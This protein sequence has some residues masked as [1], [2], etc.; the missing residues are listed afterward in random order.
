[1]RVNIKKRIKVGSKWTFAAIAKKDGKRLWD[2]CI[3][4]GKVELHKEGGYYIEWREIVDGKLKRIARPV[5]GGHKEAEAMARSQAQ[6]LDL[7]GHGHAVDDCVLQRRIKK[8]SQPLPSLNSADMKIAVEK[9]LGDKGINS[10]TGT[11]LAYS[12]SLKHFMEFMPIGPAKNL[13]RQDIKN[14]MAYLKDRGMANSTIRFHAIV[15][16]GMLRFAGAEITLPENQLPP[17]EESG[18]KPYEQE[19]IRKFLAACTDDERVIFEVFMQTGFR[20][21]E[22]AFLTWDDVDFKER[23]IRVSPKRHLDFSSKNYE[24]REITVPESL[25][26]NLADW[27][28]RSKGLFNPEQLVFPSGQYNGREGGKA[29]SE[30]LKLC[31]AIAYRGNLNCGRCK[32]TVRKT[33]LVHGKP[34]VRTVTYECK[35]GPHCKQWFLHRFRHTF[36]TVHLQFQTT[37]VRTVQVWLGHKDLATTIRYLKPA[38]GERIRKA[39]NDGTLAT[40]YSLSHEKRE[41]NVVNI[42]KGGRL[43]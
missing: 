33:V 10:K 12:S 22:V 30:F 20:N 36:A 35:N 38:R 34:E 2:H 9:Y 5:D 24:G 1:M 19:M 11:I 27:K 42:A 29:R 17:M 18:R 4:N 23:V 37:D 41:D 40:A 7:R 14:Y 31:K 15:A 43:S 6:V 28:K 26:D 25:L 3:V 13:T 16:L 39:V 8:A 32:R 21:R